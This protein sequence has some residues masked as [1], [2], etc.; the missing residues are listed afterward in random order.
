MKNYQRE[1]LQHVAGQYFSTICMPNNSLSNAQT[2]SWNVDHSF[3]EFGRSGA[4]EK[5]GTM[6]AK[7]WCGNEDLNFPIFSSVIKNPSPICKCRIWTQIQHRFREVGHRAPIES[8]LFEY[9]LQLDQCPIPFVLFFAFMT[10]VSSQLHI[11]ILLR[12]IK[13]LSAEIL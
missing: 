11:D 2:T 12:D 10:D 3:G 1:S 7:I 13:G 9:S 8:G 4:S 5:S 6:Y